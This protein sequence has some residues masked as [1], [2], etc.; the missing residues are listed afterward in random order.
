M[1]Y[2]HVDMWYR[3]GEDV[4]EGVTMQHQGCKPPQ[5]KNLMAFF[6]SLKSENICHRMKKVLKEVISSMLSAHWL[7]EFPKTITKTN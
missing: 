2:N 4:L 1:E 3:V 6:F 5:E 7:T